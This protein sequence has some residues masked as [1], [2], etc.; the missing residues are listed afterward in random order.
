MTDVPAANDAKTVDPADEA[1]LE[2]IRVRL[3]DFLAAN[4][5]SSIAVAETTKGPAVSVMSPWGD[6]SVVLMVPPNDDRFDHALNELILPERLSAIYHRGTKKLEVIWTAYTLAQSQLEIAGRSFQFGFD[7]RSYTCEF[8]ASSKELVL[9]SRYAAT[10]GMTA[11]NHRNLGSFISF[12][13]GADA[14]VQELDEPRSFWVH[15][16]EWEEDQVLRMIRNLN[17]YLTYYDASSPTV[18]IHS[19]DLGGVDAR[20]RYTHGSFPDGIIG[21]PLD[22]V[23]L[24]FWSAAQSGDNSRRYLYYYRIIEYASFFYL[25]QAAKAAVRKILASPHAATDVAGVTE[26][27]MGAI[28]ESRLDEYAK[29]AA[30]IRDNVDIKILWREIEVNPDPFTQSIEFDGGYVLAP[31][32]ANGCREADFCVKGLENFTKAIRDIRNALSHGRDQKTAAVITPTV[33]NLKKLRPWVHLIAAAA[34]E[35]ALYK[36]LS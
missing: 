7:G 3:A 23:I 27:V 31:L 35:V 18:L 26:K 5:G 1:M 34:G 17:F 2:P 28:S 15:D 33:S 19:P 12:A 11:T 22:D 4:P 14:D 20:V 16:I 9:L 36:D 30:V 13:H 24:H 6:D 8:G 21:K 10:A 25:D 32:I 29:F